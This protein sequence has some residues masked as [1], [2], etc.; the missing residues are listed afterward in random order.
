MKYVL[1]AVAVAATALAPSA[2]RASSLIINGSF[3]DGTDPG[4]FTTYSAGDLG[5]V[6]WAIVTGSVDHIG[7]YWQP[8][9]GKRRLDLSGNGPG[10][11]AQSF[12]TTA[13]MKYHVSFD[14][15]GNPDDQGSS[16]IKTLV[17]EA[18]GNS[19]L[20]LDLK[21]FDTTS[22]S[23][24][25]MGWVSYGY[26]FIADNSLSTIIFASATQSAFGP[27]LDN[28]GVAAVPVPAALPL[29]AGGLAGLAAFA[30]R[31]RKAR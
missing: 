7:T 23:K 20:V 28:V 30:A 27:A 25:N 22:T 24:S 3:E 26:D 14:L 2:A 21:T 12:A 31:R 15:A 1:V 19:L 5:L 17:Y 4:V 6:G 11:I 13:G 9:D 29:F 8:S 10:E 18:V 16:P